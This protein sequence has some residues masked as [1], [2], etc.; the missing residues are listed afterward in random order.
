MLLIK[1]FNTS[2]FILMVSD[3]SGRRSAN[4]TE[5]RGVRPENKIVAR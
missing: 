2:P 1:L 4:E 5:R 3:R